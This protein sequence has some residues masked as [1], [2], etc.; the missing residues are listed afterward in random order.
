MTLVHIGR[1]LLLAVWAIQ[2]CWFLTLGRHSL[3]RLLHPGL[4]WLVACG[5]F[6]L[7]LFLLASLHRK[8]VSTGRF[9]YMELTSQ[10][11]L[12]MPILFF[13]HV[14]NASFNETTLTTRT[15]NSDA[16]LR[17]QAFQ[18]KVARDIA[19]ESGNGETS[20]TRLYF[21]AE[22]FAGKEVEVVCQTFVDEKLPDNRVM[23][24]RYLVTCCAAD[25]QPIFLFINTEGKEPVIGKRWIKVRGR[26]AL[27]G[28][29]SRKVVS[30]IP[31]SLE[32]VQEPAFPYAY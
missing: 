30:I 9:P 25:A 31:D 8:Q 10:L 27:M 26:A 32:Y 13:L 23:C 15:I 17:M 6:V 3:A 12:L 18:D 20:L 11:V 14:R 16:M 28:E 24:Y 4:W 2:F 29:T 21:Q 22:S 7:C 19:A 1:I 5:A